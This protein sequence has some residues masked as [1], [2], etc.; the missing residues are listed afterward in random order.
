MNQD[1]RALTLATIVAGRDLDGLAAHLSADVRLRA[2]LPGGPIEQ[3][4]RDGVLA[5][6][7]KWFRGYRTVTLEDAAG[8]LVGDRLIVHYRLAFDTAAGPRVLTQTWV[9]SLDESGVIFRI[10]LLCSGFREP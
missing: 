10:D 6:F 2:L 3:H 4:G 9:S 7:T 8:E 5:T 1:S